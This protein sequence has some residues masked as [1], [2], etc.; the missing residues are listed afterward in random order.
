MEPNRVTTQPSSLRIVPF[1]IC[2][3]ILI[4]NC[5]PFHSQECSLD[6]KLYGQLQ[7]RMLKNFLWRSYQ[8]MKDRE[9][10]VVL[11]H[12]TCSLKCRTTQNVFKR[13]RSQRD[14]HGLFHQL[15]QWLCNKQSYREVRLSYCESIWHNRIN[16]ATSDARTVCTSLNHQVKPKMEGVPECQLG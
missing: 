10:L 3:S 2:C 4:I 15:L 16:T 7:S 5:V 8:P 1:Y 11:Y 14:R 6:E 13:H 9:F 12:V